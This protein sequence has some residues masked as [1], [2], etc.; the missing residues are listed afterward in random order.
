MSGVFSPDGRWVAYTMTGRTMTVCVE[1]FPAT[2]PPVCLEPNMA[3][4]PKHP[5]WSPDGKEL[6]IDPRIGD[7]ESVA[8]I[9]SPT[10]SLGK[11]TPVEKHFQ[12]APPGSRTPYD[13][14][15]KGRYAGQ[16]VGLIGGEITG[17]P[18]ALKQIV[19]V[20]NWYDD[21]KARVTR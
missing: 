20:L 12:L 15:Q 10:L 16:F 6:F 14:I 11:R 18:A 21:L 4:S 1:P 8:V 9:T 5:R 13:I 2:T 19:V 17:S 3:D 7:F